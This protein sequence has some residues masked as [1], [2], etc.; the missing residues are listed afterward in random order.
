MIARDRESMRKRRKEGAD[1]GSDEEAKAFSVS[2]RRH[3]VRRE[4]GE[5]LEE[6]TE[7]GERFPSYVEKLTAQMEA[8]DETLREYISA[9]KKM[10]EEMEAARARMAQD[11]ERRL[12]L[13]KQ[14]FFAGLLPFLD[15]LDRA[16][17]A[18]E[19]HQDYEGLV[20]GITM[21]RD[22]FLQKLRD[23][24]VERIRS[25][26][27]PF[28][29]AYHEAMAVVDV[30][31][32]EEDNRVIEELSPGYLYRD[33][34]LRAAQVRVGQLAVGSTNRPEDQDHADL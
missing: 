31:A 15:H 19:D 14:E 29:P 2:D 5:E 21:V 6:P 20:K 34:L 7:P 30:E 10:K 22:L 32:P 27:E 25:V 24:G 33:A 17:S 8:K 11:M 4:S 3:W 28:D 26:G 9:H 1:T 18:A 12:E 23:E 13:H 16:V